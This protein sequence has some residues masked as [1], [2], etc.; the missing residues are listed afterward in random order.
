MLEIFRRLSREYFLRLEAE[1]LSAGT[2]LL[3]VGCGGS[4]PIRFFSHKL[5][6]AVGVDAFLPAIEQSRAHKIHHEYRQMDV[7][8]LETAFPPQSFDV[9][10][11]LDV[12]EHFEKA[13]G[14]QLIASMERIA[15]RKV[16]IFTP[17]G[18]QPQGDFNDNPYQLHR[19]GWTVKDMRALG[20]SVSGMSGYKPL[21][22]AHSEVKWKPKLFWHRV[23]VLTQPLVRHIPH[24]AYQLFCVKTFSDA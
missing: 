15:R 4:S 12:I 13:D 20:Y 3:D 1:V 23:S 18:F 11:A 10:V 19:S 17:N 14:Y 8:A 5:H 9:V 21:R 16:I 24:L 2:T 6:Y 22:G 7:L